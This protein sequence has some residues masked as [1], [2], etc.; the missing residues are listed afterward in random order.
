MEA[1]EWLR[2]Y[3]KVIKVSE[4]EKRIACS[5][6]VL[7]KAVNGERVLPDR[8]KVPLD[9]FVFGLLFDIKGE[10][11]NES[12]EIYVGGDAPVVDGYNVEREFVKSGGLRNPAL[13]A[14]I[15]PEGSYEVDKPMVGGIVKLPKHLK[16]TRVRGKNNDTSVPVDMSTVDVTTG[17]IKEKLEPVRIKWL[18][19][20]VEAA[21]ETVEPWISKSGNLYE[22]KKMF[23]SIAKY[24]YVTNLEDARRIVEAKNPLLVELS[25]KK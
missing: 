13:M 21:Y 6:N 18:F 16:A 8:W 23:G 11:C 2:K 14:P 20:R 3:S 10:K 4:V 9:E 5:V 22:V 15:V 25:V 24:V 7:Q 19:N 1:I 17:E 12:K